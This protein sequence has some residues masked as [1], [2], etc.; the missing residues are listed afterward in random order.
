MS[1]MQNPFDR[2]EPSQPE[3]AILTDIADITYQTGDIIYYDGANLVRLG[4][5]TSGQALVVDSGLP[6]WGTL[7]LSSSPGTENDPTYVW[8]EVFVTAGTYA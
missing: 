1:S 7:Q 3:S 6:A 4:I 2:E 8:N 5:G